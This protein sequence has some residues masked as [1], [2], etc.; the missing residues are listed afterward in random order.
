MQILCANYYCFQQQCSLRLIRFRNVTSFHE[1]QQIDLHELIYSIYR[2]VIFSYALTVPFHFH[3]ERK[4]CTGKSVQL[5]MFYQLL[6]GLE[7][8]NTTTSVTLILNKTLTLNCIRICPAVLDQCSGSHHY[9]NLHPYKYIFDICILWLGKNFLT[10][11]EDALKEE[12][13]NVL[14]NL[15]GRLTLV[16]D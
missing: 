7:Q 4:H 11:H 2:P 12:D 8:L 10:M 3:D 15:W 6:L 16:L 14:L 5:V 9:V 13:G 1:V